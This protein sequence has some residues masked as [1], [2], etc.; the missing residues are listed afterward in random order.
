MCMTSAEP[1]S[2]APGKKPLIVS[3][4]VAESLNASAAVAA[5]AAVA[6]KAASTTPVAAKADQPCKSVPCG[7]T[8]SCV[9]QLPSELEE[10]HAEAEAEEADN[11][12][13]DDDDIDES[14][15]EEGSLVVFSMADKDLSFRVF[16]EDG[17]K[18]VTIVAHEPVTVSL[19][20]FL[21]YAQDMD[22]SKLIVVEDETRRYHDRRLLDNTSRALV[23]LSLAILIAVCM[24][25][26]KCKW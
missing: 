7:N 12:A 9:C 10:E 23:L 22:E 16:V 6:A 13:E 20:T 11:E 4:A 25:F 14:I 2:L 15:Y 5:N 1:A 26:A 8:C 3:A 17:V 18:M 24:P 19:N 21:S